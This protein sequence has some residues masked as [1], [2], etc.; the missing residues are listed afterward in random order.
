M[1]L[2][3]LKRCIGIRRISANETQA[4]PPICRIMC[5]DHH[6][7]G[8]SHLRNLIANQASTR[9]ITRVAHQHHPR[10]LVSYTNTGPGVTHPIG[11]AARASHIT[12]GTGLRLSGKFQE[13]GSFIIP[14]PTIIDIRTS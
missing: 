10:V 3:V 5:K 4:S 11:K 9:A 14:K 7:L 6:Q 1:E 12:L 2:T 13:V 8:E